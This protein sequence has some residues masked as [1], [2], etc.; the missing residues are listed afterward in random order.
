MPR[1]RLKTGKNLSKY[2]LT[3]QLF[4]NERS[5]IMYVTHLQTKYR[6]I[7]SMATIDASISIL[8]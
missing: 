6:G 8:F 5:C 4:N 3:Y 7:V 2:L 1:N